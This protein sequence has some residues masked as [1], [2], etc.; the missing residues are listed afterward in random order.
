MKKIAAPSARFNSILSCQLLNLTLFHVS[1]RNYS[2]RKYFVLK[3]SHVFEFGTIGN[4]EPAPPYADLAMGYLEI[5]L[6]YKIRAK[7]GNKVALYFWTSYRR[8]LDDGI[9]FWDKRLCDLHEVFDLLNEMH[10]SIKFTMEGSDTQ[11]KYLDIL[12]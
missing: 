2:N 6:F 11:L 9:I 7:L 4:T 5:L 3:K 8:Y 12:V 1:L 10:P